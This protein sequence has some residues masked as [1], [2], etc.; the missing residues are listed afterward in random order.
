MKRIKDIGNSVTGACT[1]IR[2]AVFIILYSL[3][4]IHSVSAQPADKLYTIGTDAYKAKN[5]QQAI[6]AYQKLVADGYRSASVYYNLGNAY[7][8]TNQISLAILAYERALRLNP[9]D[10]DIRFNLKLANLKTVDRIVPVPQLYIVSKWRSLVSS[11]SSKTWAV[12]SVVCVWLALVA[13][14]IYLFIGS[15][16]RAG[17]WAGTVLVIFFLF[18]SF[19]HLEVCR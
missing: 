1:R 12:F 8:K 10:E 13:F 2:P 17:F 11:Q 15:I 9:S 18:F 6:D 19:K 14:A 5:Y 3:F 16:R 7:Y 4:I